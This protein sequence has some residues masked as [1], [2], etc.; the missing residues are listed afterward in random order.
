MISSGLPVPYHKMST[1]S[2]TVLP[3]RGLAEGIVP[4]TDVVVPGAFRQFESEDVERAF[5]H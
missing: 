5:V 2:D 1:D 3:G 4:D